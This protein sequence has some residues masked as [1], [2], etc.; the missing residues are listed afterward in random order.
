MFENFFNNNKPVIGIDIGHSSIKIAF[1]LR[2]GKKAQLLS[3]NEIPVKNVPMSKEGIS[4][5]NT[6]ITNIRQALQTAKPHP[7]SSIITGTSLP[8]SLVFTK[9][10]TQPLITDIKNLEK[11]IPRQAEDFLPIP[12]DQV[13]LDWQIISQNHIEKEMDILI[14]A[15]PKALV[16]DLAL[17]FAAAGLKLQFIEIKPIS[18]ARSITNASEEN[19]IAIVDIGSDATGI[20]ITHRGNVKATSTLTIGAQNIIDA[21]KAT[22]KNTTASANNLVQEGQTKDV[23]NIITNGLKPIVDEV[24]KLV[25]YYQSRVESSGVV[26]EIRLCGGGS[27][28]TNVANYF[29]EMTKIPTIISNPLLNITSCPKEILSPSLLKYSV[30]IGLSLRK[31]NIK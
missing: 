27:Q 7:I 2:K 3:I 13:V 4:D 29:Q 18:L 10:I 15:A 23:N 31:I 12:I 20:S 22:E 24:I 19:P 30:A 17:V 5:K 26:K 16:N 1:V 6:L 14:I 8:S 9:L 28:I 25:K 21:I 11:S